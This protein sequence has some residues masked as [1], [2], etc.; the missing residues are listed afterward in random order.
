MAK[1]KKE[2]N[3]LTQKPVN[4]AMAKIKRTNNNLT[5]KPVNN[6]MALQVSV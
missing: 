6:T 3:D 5:Q 1:I 4:N 2:S